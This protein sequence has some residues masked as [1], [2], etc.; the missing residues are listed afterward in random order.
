MG[1]VYSM[2]RYGGRSCIEGEAEGSNR[3]TDLKQRR[4]RAGL[5]QAELAKGAGCSRQYINMLEHG[6]TIPSEKMRRKIERALTGSSVFDF[7]SVPFADPAEKRFF[8]NLYRE[9]YG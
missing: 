2:Q 6:K 1:P 8:S 3:M 4:E 9:R 5:T 7:P